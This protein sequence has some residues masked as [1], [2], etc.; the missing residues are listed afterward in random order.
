MKRKILWMMGI[1]VLV[2]A[3]IT[4]C[5]NK[6]TKNQ[7]AKEGKDMSAT[8]EEKNK[9]PGIDDFI[10]KDYT[11]SNG[12]RLSYWIYLPEEKNVPLVMWEHG[13]GETEDS[14]GK[15]GQLK[16]DDNGCTTWF[17]N[18][19]KVAVVSVQYPSN[20]GFSIR[21]NAD[22]YQKMKEYELAKYELIQDLIEDGSVDEKRLY[23]AGAS[24]GG[25][26]ALDFIVNYPDLFAGAMIL[27]AKDTLVPMSLKYGLNYQ[28]DDAKLVLSDEEYAECYKQMEK[29]L[30]GVDLSNCGIWFAQAEYDQVCTSYTSKIAYDILSKKGYNVKLTLYTDDDI[31]NTMMR[32]PAY[33]IALRNQGMID[34]L[35]EQTK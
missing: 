25:G 7:R 30:D 4:G 24:S 8:Q 15:G 1:M 32:H 22:Q 6:S 10:H 16:A 34:W 35:F 29:I 17:E 13:G 14:V 2:C 26:A 5:G 33:T 20:Y 3:L 27:S 28:F 19:R 9:K 12:T 23:I 11:A 31:E 18:N 21:D